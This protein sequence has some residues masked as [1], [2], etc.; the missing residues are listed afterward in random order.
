VRD[1]RELHEGAVAIITH[2]NPTPPGLERVA[3][4]G[5]VR[6]YRRARER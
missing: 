3:A 1:D 6:V 4:Y 5:N 2:M